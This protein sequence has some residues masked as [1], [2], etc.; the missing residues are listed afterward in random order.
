M[1]LEELT[2]ALRDCPSRYPDER[3]KKLVRRALDTTLELAIKHWRLRLEE[4]M[5]ESALR[6]T[7]SLQ[8]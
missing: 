1:S 4:A 8:T 2:E 6:D 5:S 7:G 3:C